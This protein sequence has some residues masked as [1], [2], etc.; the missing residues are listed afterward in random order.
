MATTQNKG[1]IIM[2]DEYQYVGETSG[3]MG[4]YDTDDIDVLL[5]QVMKDPTNSHDIFGD[6]IDPYAEERDE[7][8]GEDT[9]L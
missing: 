2:N 1:I 8:F 9:C 6:G 4:W 3:A 5:D 7:N